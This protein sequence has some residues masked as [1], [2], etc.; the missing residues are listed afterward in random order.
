MAGSECKGLGRAGNDYNGSIGRLCHR[1][2][3]THGIVYRSLKV[4]D[5]VV[6]VCLRPPSDGSVSPCAQRSEGDP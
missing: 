2:Q 3:H 1:G 6:A 4:A 5:T